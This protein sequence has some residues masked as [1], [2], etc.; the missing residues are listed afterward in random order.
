[1]P[2]RTR[3]LRPSLWIDATTATLPDVA[4]RLYLGLA[5]C[6]DDEGWLLWRPATL[7][8]HLFRYLAPDERAPLLDSGSTALR[9]AGLL[10]VHDCGCAEL[11]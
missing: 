11:A 4:F 2:E 3:I 8:A 7:G 10:I 1:M 6:A 9:E 5:T